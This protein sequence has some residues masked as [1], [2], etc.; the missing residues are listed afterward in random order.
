MNIQR[1]LAFVVFAGLLAMP[2]C[3]SSS[4]TTDEMQNRIV[5]LEEKLSEAQTQIDALTSDLD[6][7][8]SNQGESKVPINEDNP[9]G[10]EEVIEE[11]QTDEE[12]TNNHNIGAETEVL[13]AAYEWYENS[14]DVR[15]LQEFLGIEPD[16][17][18]G[19]YT[20]ATHLSALEEM[21][22]PTN[23][24]PELG[25]IPCPDPEPLPDTQ[26]VGMS[27]FS[28]D[29]DGDG[30]LELVNVQAGTGVNEGRFFAVASSNEFGT[31]WVETEFPE[32]EWRKD[33]VTDINN[34]G[35]DEFW[36]RHYP[37]GAS[38]E[39]YS[40]IIFENCDM[41]IARIPDSNDLWRTGGTVM[42]SW[43]LQCE[44]QQDGEG[45]HG[46]FLKQYNFWVDGDGQERIRVMG[47]RFDGT[48][49]EFYF[50]YEDEN[51][52]NISIPNDQECERWYQ[53][54][55]TDPNY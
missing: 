10:P 55:P 18:Y 14:D 46:H 16:G 13:I 24:V 12:G 39:S 25:L 28:A 6:K 42:S 22:L 4:D 51:A 54:H 33:S 45:S 5:D 52:E 3:S 31:R 53:V 34:D 1:V 35:R 17:I 20:R 27:S 29:M 11:N 32:E 9:V 36:V 2:A 41:R 19:P 21:G 48:G 40:V 23:G 37:G 26:S 47:Y 30:N 50:G 43:S 8:E 44:F 15:N 38:V 49:F 7:E